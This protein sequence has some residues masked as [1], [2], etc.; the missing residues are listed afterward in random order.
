MLTVKDDG[1]YSQVGLNKIGAH[2]LSSQ[3]LP[4]QYE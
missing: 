4:I 3:D 1:I 2:S